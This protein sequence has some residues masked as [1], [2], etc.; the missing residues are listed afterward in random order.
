[1]SATQLD[2]FGEVQAA[3]TSAERQQADWLARLSDGDRLRCPACG[4][5]ED[6]ATDLQYR[7]GFETDLTT[8]GHPYPYCWPGDHDPSSG[9]GSLC[10]QRRLAWL[11]ATYPDQA[12]RA[13]SR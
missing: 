9:N 6:T 3:I 5:H 13:P 10:M 2:L 8:Q 1:M 7:H 12:H 11:R 4:A